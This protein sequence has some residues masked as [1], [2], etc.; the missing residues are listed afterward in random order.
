MQFL[1]GKHG[2]YL[3]LCWLLGCRFSLCG[4]SGRL[5]AAGQAID[6]SCVFQGV[7][8]TWSCA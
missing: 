2:L 7:H 5:Q 1:P 3:S 6:N 8:V 4:F